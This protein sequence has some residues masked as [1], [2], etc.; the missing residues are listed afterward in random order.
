M[1]FIKFLLVL[2]ALKWFWPD[3]SS[4]QL[5][6]ETHSIWLDFGTA[7]GTLL[8]VVTALFIGPIRNWYIRPV[9]AITIG[10]EVPF[11]RRT[12]ASVNLRTG[13]QSSGEAFWLRLKIK[14]VGRSSAKRCEAKLVTIA[15]S[16]LRSLRQD[17]DP[18]VLHWVG[19]DLISE[20]TGVEHSLHYTKSG[21]TDINAG[22]YEFLDLLC[23]QQDRE[24]FDIQAIDTVPRGINF[25]PG[26]D[27]YYFLIGL[28][29]DNAV[30]T[31]F[32]YKINYGGSWDN[33]KI[34]EVATEEKDKLH[35]LL[36]D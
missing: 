18:V 4:W 12:S 36:K 19:G 14:N 2:V 13:R 5:A 3:F 29:S 34:E 21:Y 17:F 15:H 8:A 35:K 32:V 6:L 25:S 10:N 16:D 27:T 23:S 24:T 33:I 28:Y 30:S 7:I 22:E 31:S 11:V 9:L 20:T 26:R 1:T